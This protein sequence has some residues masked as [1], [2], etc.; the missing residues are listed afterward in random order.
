M[1][2]WHV[3][4]HGSPETRSV[5]CTG[6]LSVVWTSWKFCGR[7]PEPGPVPAAAKP[8]PGRWE[9]GGRAA[10]PARPLPAPRLPA[11]PAPPAPPAPGSAPSPRGPLASGPPLRPG[12]EGLGSAQRVPAHVPPRLPAP[13]FREELVLRQ[14][15]VSVVTAAGALVASL[16]R[17][18]GM[19][20]RDGEEVS[21]L[22]QRRP[23]PR[24]LGA[25]WKSRSSLSLHKKHAQ[26]ACSPRTAPRGLS[27][28]DKPAAALAQPAHPAPWRCS[29]ARGWG[30]VPA[31][32]MSSY[33]TG[34]MSCAPGWLVRSG[35]KQAWPKR[36]GECLGDIPGATN[37]TLGDVG[38]D[39]PY[40]EPLQWVCWGCGP[41]LP[42]QPQQPQRIALLWPHHPRWE[43]H[44]GPGLSWR[45][46]GTA[47]GHSSVQSGL[48]LSGYGPWRATRWHCYGALHAHC[49]AQARTA[50]SSQLQGCP[51][52]AG[53]SI[54]S[55]DVPRAAAL[56]S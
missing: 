32:S 44:R 14:L 13:S 7:F 36:T 19:P 53:M 20:N 37:G 17:L 43:S 6:L 40:P 35:D 55:R 3:P 15:G 4:L 41:L 46:H 24:P 54:S 10:V 25:G 18:L 26:E 51:S 30:R 23:S 38:E 2:P 22:E 11:G 27:T 5:R 31:K 42:E 12:T 33:L 8:R 1:T 28:V 39:S 50:A 34:S 49:G 9:R 56:S 45:C 48:G 47:R 29:R 52:A 16:A 21:A